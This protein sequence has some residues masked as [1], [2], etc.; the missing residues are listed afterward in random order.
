M[1]FIRLR[2][3]RRDEDGFSLVFVGTGMMAFVAV[4][5]LVV[6]GAAGIFGFFMLKRWR[7]AGTAKTRRKDAPDAVT[8]ARLDARLDAEL[9]ALDD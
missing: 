9:K 4:S 7:R 1:R 6:I 2:K 3:F 8:D 5:M